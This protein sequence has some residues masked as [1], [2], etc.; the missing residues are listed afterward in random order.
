MDGMR[1]RFSLFQGHIDL[2]HSFWKKIVSPGD[3]VVDA[4]CG[5][6]FD[7]LIL[8]KLA[9]HNNQGHLFCFDIQNQAIE[10]TKG[11]LKEYPQVTYIHGSHSTIKEVLQDTQAKLIVY[12][13]G[14]LP[15][16][17]KSITTKHTS[18]LESI[19][20]ALLCL[21]PGG[22]ISITC[23]PGH[24]EGKI[25]ESVIMQFCKSLSPANWGVSSHSWPN[26]NN[27]PHL[28]FIQKPV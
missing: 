19:E 2:A 21:C 26:R 8:A 12:N 25:E 3:T 13:L 16:A 6:G 23:Y 10:A 22:V 11:K 18:T 28:I 15:G 20:K 14:Y 17:A 9:L 24:D 7:S 1:A 4:T 5:N 27:H